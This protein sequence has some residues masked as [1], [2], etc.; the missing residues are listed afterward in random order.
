M[1]LKFLSVAKIAGEGGLVTG[2][3]SLLYALPENNLDGVQVGVR[4]VVKVEGGVCALKD[5][6]LTASVWEDSGVEC[7]RA[8]VLLSRKLVE[9]A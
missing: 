1:A 8:G 5:K 7:E 4:T 6:P 9:D 3:L 2:Y